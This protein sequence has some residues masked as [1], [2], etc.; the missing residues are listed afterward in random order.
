M[1]LERTV[2]TLSDQVKLLSS[3]PPSGEPPKQQQH[4]LPPMAQ[5]QSQMPNTMQRMPMSHGGPMGQ[6]PQQQQIQQQQQQQPPQQ[7]PPGWYP[8]P[9]ETQPP[10]VPAWYGNRSI[11][12]PQPSHPLQP[13]PVEKPITSEEM[14]K[15]EDHFLE[16]LS[17][18]ASSKDLINLLARTNIDTVMP[19]RPDALTISQTLVIV[20][21]HRV[22]G[23]CHFRLSSNA[24]ILPF[25][26]ILLSSTRPPRPT[27]LSSWQCNG[28]TGRSSSFVLM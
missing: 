20:I 22:S 11:A 6:V 2:R 15:Y 8:Q 4:Q 5:M 1:Q 3:R 23:C 25:D 21:I 9:Q 28:S 17:P 27:W 18:N 16:A 13:P 10:Q 7:P 26:R 19:L 14:S 24:D 12:A